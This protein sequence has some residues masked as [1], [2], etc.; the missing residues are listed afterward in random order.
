MHTFTHKNHCLPAQLT[1][2]MLREELCNHSPL[3][4]GKLSWLHLGF[5]PACTWLQKRLAVATFADGDNYITQVPSRVPSGPLHKFK[6]QLGFNV[7]LFTIEDRSIKL[8]A[9]LK[10]LNW[11]C[12]IKVCKKSF[13]YVK[14]CLKTRLRQ[15][16][17]IGIGPCLTRLRH[18]G[19]ESSENGQSLCK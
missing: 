5:E 18:E 6:W 9:T 16:S 19:S 14:I 11:L 2:T 17:E 13:V 3:N 4:L 15:R 10:K 1:L 12:A 7:L 8:M